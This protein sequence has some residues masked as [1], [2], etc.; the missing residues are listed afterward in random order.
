MAK[1]T[2]TGTR[3]D[4]AYN[5]RQIARAVCFTAHLR[6]GPGEK[7]TVRCETLEEARAAASRLNADHGAYGRRASVY[8]VNPEGV[9][10]HV[11]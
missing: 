6:V 4:D 1:R 11:A 5:A 9:G 2:A 3:P 7:H 8:A 10:F